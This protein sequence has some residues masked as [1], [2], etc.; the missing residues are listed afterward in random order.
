[1]FKC[2]D[3]DSYTVVVNTGQMRRSDPVKSDPL[4]R[5]VNQTG[6]ISVRHQ[7]HVFFFCLPHA[8]R[9]TNRHRCSELLAAFLRDVF[10]M[11]LFLNFDGFQ[12]NFDLHST[13]AALEKNMSSIICC[14]FLPNCFVSLH[15]N[16]M[17]KVVAKFSHSN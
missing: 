3:F 11:V 17:L 10:G 1:M 13:A 14:L 16:T 4:L 5:T 8:R 6:S 15:Q 12:F 7:Q 9:N 2:S